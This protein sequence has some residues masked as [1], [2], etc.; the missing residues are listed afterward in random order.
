MKSLKNMAVPESTR[1][2]PHLH[3]PKEVFV[4]ERITLKNNF[5][6]GS[7]KGRIGVLFQKK[8]GMTKIKKERH[9]A[10]VMGKHLRALGLA[11]RF[12]FHVSRAA[13]WGGGLGGSL[14]PR[15]QGTSG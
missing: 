3:N 12:N 9:E 8:E 2:K 11:L 6:Y 7:Y 14:W 1:R 13:A 10:F 15:R 5:C 4:R